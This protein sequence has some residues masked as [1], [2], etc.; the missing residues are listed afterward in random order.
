MP[1]QN[2]KHGYGAVTKTLHWVTF[3]L[4]LGQFLVG[5]S[6]SGEDPAAEAAAER[7]HDAKDQCRATA[8]SDAAEAAEERCEEE[9]DRREDALDDRADD[10]VGTAW[11]DL[12]SRDI[13]GD[14]ISLPELH[15][16]L[17]LLILAMG[18]LRV[19][20]RR[21]TPLP[22]WAPALSSAERTLESLLEK[23]LL[24]LLFVVPGTGLLLVAGEDD[25]LS[26]HI[27]AH[28]AFF[29]V[30]GLHIGLVL[31]HTV[32]QRDR[33]LARML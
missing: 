22:P 13:L 19:A 11:D 10:A 21:T 28:I 2:G 25:W 7:L 6:M 29:V 18:V 15:V 26:L 8:D 33:H 23:A 9:L 1:L 5:Y 20:W 24:L 3:S 4:I 30:V 31:K 27:A 17:G 32:I 12:R 16:I 14:G